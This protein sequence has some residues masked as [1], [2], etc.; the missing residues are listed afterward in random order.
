MIMIIIIIM[1]NDYN[2]NNHIIIKI[3]IMRINIQN[4]TIAASWYEIFDIVYTL[5]F[6]TVL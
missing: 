5:S 6:W 2:E 4:P 1:N 3:L